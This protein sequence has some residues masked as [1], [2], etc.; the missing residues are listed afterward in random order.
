MSTGLVLATFYA[1]GD[2]TDYDA[3]ARLSIQTVFGTAAGVAFDAVTLTIAPGSVL[4][5]VQI[6]VVDV[7]EANTVSTTLLNGIL[8]TS[9]ALESALTSAGVSSIKVISTPTVT[10]VSTLQPPA[11]PPG[12]KYNRL[13]IGL[14]VGLGVGIPVLLLC[15]FCLVRTKQKQSFG[16]SSLGGASYQQ[17][18]AMSANTGQVK[19][20]VSDH[21]KPAPPQR[22]YKSPK[23]NE[24]VMGLQ[25]A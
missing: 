8:S 1:S 24:F 22:P 17:G 23:N 15:L 12:N 10:A 19:L 7:S 6:D 25:S 21:A 5:Q 16:S 20:T 9:S 2:V 13:A 4:I 3:S 14:G 11:A 18:V